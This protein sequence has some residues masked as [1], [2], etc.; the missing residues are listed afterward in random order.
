[1][2]NVVSVTYLFSPVGVSR[3]K[4]L[5]MKKLALLVLFAAG[6]SLT[7]LA[8]AAA[9]DQTLFLGYSQ[10]SAD[11]AK[12]AVNNNGNLFDAALQSSNPFGGDLS[13]TRDNNKN[14][15]GGVIKYRYEFD[16]SVGLIVTANYLLGEFGNTARRN[17]PSANPGQTDSYYYK[18]RVKADHFTLMSG[19]TYRFNELLSVY[20]TLGMAY[21]H[22]GI[23]SHSNQIVDGISTNM[24]DSSQD[25]NKFS[26][27]SSVG[28]HVNVWKDL[29]VDA[30]YDVS[31]SG[32]WKTNGFN[33]GLG[34]RF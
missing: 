23:S 10:A 21:N 32:D 28:F 12:K 29:V 18:N 33:V 27:A 22:I 7:S 5:L 34:Y 20:A 19:P 15:A 14:L 24:A 1:M 3:F 25:K 31:G 16:D 13:V 2:T 17:K 26:L 8:Q 11:W 4:G 9:G 6:S 30:A